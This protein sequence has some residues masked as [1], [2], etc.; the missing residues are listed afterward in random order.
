MAA[1]PKESETKSLDSLRLWARDKDIGELLRRTKWGMAKSS[2]PWP[3]AD[4]TEGGKGQMCDRPQFGPG[5]L[6]MC[7][8]GAS[9]AC[10]Y[11]FI[12]RAFGYVNM[13]NRE[14]PI[15]VSSCACGRAGC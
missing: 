15:H 3:G 12:Q 14:S 1:R 6:A 10:E 13:M 11:R 7:E 9:A 5:P 8:C 2:L 4:S